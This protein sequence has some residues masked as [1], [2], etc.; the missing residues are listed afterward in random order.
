MSTGLANDAT[1]KTFWAN[2]LH[3][4]ERGFRLV[5]EKFAREIPK[6]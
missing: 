6:L 3:P 2:E 5:A 4:T 1:Y